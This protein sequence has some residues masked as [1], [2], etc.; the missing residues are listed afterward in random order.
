MKFI[1]LQTA[2]LL[3]AI[4]FVISVSVPL[5]S[6]AESD[7][8][9]APESPSHWLPSPFLVL[10]KYF[11]NSPAEADRRDRILRRYFAPM[12]VPA[13]YT[14]PTTKH[15]LMYPNLFRYTISSPY[16]GIYGNPSLYGFGMA[17]Q[18]HAWS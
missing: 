17:A 2:I 8:H 14:A 11:E 5:S 18:E 1:C 9:P 15:P 4:P 3:V 16:A 7:T 10:S 13:D 12:A 6:E